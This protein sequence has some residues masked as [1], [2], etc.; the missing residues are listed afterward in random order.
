MRT[1]I[2]GETRG[3]RGPRLALGHPTVCPLPPGPPL[4]RG[5]LGAVPQALGWALT[6]LAPPPNPR[7]L[8]PA[9]SSAS[10]SPPLS[11]PLRSPS[12]PFGACPLA[13]PRARPLWRVPPRPASCSALSVSFSPPAVSPS[14]PSSLALAPLP[15]LVFSDACSLSLST[16]LSRLPSLTPHPGPQPS[17]PPRPLSLFPSLSLS[18]IV[19]SSLPPCGACGVSALRDVAEQAGWRAH[20]CCCCCDLRQGPSPLLPPPISLLPKDGYATAS[21]HLTSLEHAVHGDRGRRSLSHRWSLV[22]GIERA[23]NLC[24]RIYNQNSYA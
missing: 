4:G 18:L 3:S 22:P 21:F 13:R 17:L 8:V 24:G 15:P 23:L 9:A 14:V 11:P 7:G 20:L 5:E 6:M 1:S 16:S 10:E 2:G 12:G 19:C